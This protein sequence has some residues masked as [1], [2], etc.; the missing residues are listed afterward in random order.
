MQTGSF[1]HASKK[2]Y[3][4]YYTWTLD[5]NGKR[6]QKKACKQL[7]PWNGEDEPPEKIKRYAAEILQPENAEVKPQ[8]L[9]TF[10]DFVDKLY[11]P[12]CQKVKRPATYQ[13]YADAWKTLRPHVPVGLTLRDF[14]PK[15]G[16]DILLGVDQ[17][18]S[19][20]TFTRLKY[21]LYGALEYAISQEIIG[22]GTSGWGN[23][24]AHVKQ[25]KGL[26]P[27]EKEPYSA[28]EIAT[29]LRVVTDQVARTMILVAALLGLRKSEIAGLCWEDIDEARQTIKVRRSIYWS[30]TP[31]IVTDGPCEILRYNVGATKTKGS[32]AEL[33]ISP[34]VMK[35]LLALK[36]SPK[37]T[38]WIFRR[39]GPL[40]P[41]NMINYHIEP[42]LAGT[43]VEWRG[44]HSFRHGV[45]T[46]LDRPD[47]TPKTAQ[48]LMRHSNISTTLNVYTHA[49]SKAARR[50][51]E[52]LDAALAEAEAKIA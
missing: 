14:G 29:M 4:R 3:L 19:K 41:A 18:R 42:K 38:G 37:A 24:M 36:P 11:L 40:D 5:S 1:F 47:V 44:W 21:F 15:A 45:A 10:V 48:Q 35:A 8:A 13:A 39:K 12:A 7:G 2:W 16:R 17:N 22:D 49:D 23:P 52:A 6:V 27:K 50:A 34:R 30:R 51:A 46:L 9:A 20:H 25:P 33:P 26:D 43:G 28:D 32:K 31:K